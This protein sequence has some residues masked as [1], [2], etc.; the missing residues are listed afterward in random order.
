MA[1]PKKTRCKHGHKWTPENTAYDAKGAR[2]CR[3]CNR[4]RMRKPPAPTRM[5]RKELHDLNDEENVLRDVLGRRRGCRPCY[6]VAGR[7]RNQ[8]NLDAARR[9]RFRI[10]YGITVEEYDEMVVDQGGKCKICLNPPVDRCLSVDH[11]HVTGKVR[12]LL[13]SNCNSMLGYAK[14]NPVLLRRGID[15]LLVNGATRD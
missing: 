8:K 13:C 6:L 7:E 12:G 5:C 11:D 2:V 1:Y 4:T 3:E 15:Y 9:S 10:E 14:D